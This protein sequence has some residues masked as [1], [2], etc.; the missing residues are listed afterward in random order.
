MEAK[1]YL[2]IFVLG[3]SNLKARVIN[4]F[5]NHSKTGIINHGAMKKRNIEVFFHSIGNQNLNEIKKC[6]NYQRLNCCNAG[7]NYTE[8]ESC[9]TWGNNFVRKLCY[10][11]N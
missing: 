3:T 7:S 1:N 5:A 6:F 8:K 4:I 9:C 11:V 2:L 10:G